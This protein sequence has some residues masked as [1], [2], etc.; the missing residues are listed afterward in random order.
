[1]VVTIV[2][3]RETMVTEPKLAVQIRAPSK[4]M[5]IGL[6]PKALVKVVT[7]LAWKSTPK[8]TV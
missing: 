2:G 8:Y 1:M 7:A 4:A 3:L 6:V 5:H